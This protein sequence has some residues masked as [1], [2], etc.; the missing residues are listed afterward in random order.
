MSGITKTINGA[1]GTSYSYNDLARI[2][3]IANPNKISLGQVIGPSGGIPNVTTQ[4]NADMKT[5]A[6]NPKVQDPFAFRSLV[7]GGG[8]W[9]LKNTNTYSSAKYKNG[10]IYH[11]PFK[12]QDIKIR[13]D[14]PGN[15]N[16]G[17]TG[18]AAWWA[19]PELLHQEAGKANMSDAAARG[20]KISPLWVQCCNGDDPVDYKYIDYGIKLHS[21]GVLK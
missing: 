17:F 10:F 3:N 19:W 21:S 11:D 20:Q 2:N 9:D 13:S 15:M 5:N 14:A 4:V 7:T 18:D 12:D 1:Y 16:F 8:A 6:G